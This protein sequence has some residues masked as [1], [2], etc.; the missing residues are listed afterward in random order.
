MSTDLTIAEM[1][2]VVAEFVP[3]ASEPDDLARYARASGDLN[4]LHLDPEFA[5]QAGFDNLVVHGMLGMAH[6]GRLLTDN[7]PIEQI[8]SF[9][10]RFGA[11][12]LA[13]QTVSYRARLIERSTEFAML[14]LEAS[15]SSGK[16]A[17]TG[18]AEVL[19]G[20]KP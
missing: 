9:N 1:N 15:D 7:F 4:P 19:L 10:A 8:R 14:A 20:L 13:G 18:R 6:L 17:I 16:T 2:S 5:R 12:I 11:V 3:P